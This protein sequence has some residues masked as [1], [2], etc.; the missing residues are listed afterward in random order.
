MR[1][2]ARS[3]SVSSYRSAV[4]LWCSSAKRRG[5]STS[6]RSR[7]SAIHVNEKSLAI[8]RS[9]AR[10]VA[11]SYTSATKR[12]PSD[13]LRK[14]RARTAAS[15]FGYPE[16]FDRQL[17]DR[18]NK[19]LKR[20]RAPA[21]GPV[22][23]SEGAGHTRTARIDPPAAHCRPRRLVGRAPAARGA[24]GGGLPRRVVPRPQPRRGRRPGPAQPD[25]AGADLAHPRG[26]LRGRRRHRHHEHVHGDDD[27]PG[28]LRASGPRSSRR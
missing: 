14:L 4:G 17:G 20:S 21:P 3:S 25:A 10:S 12:H 8:S 24:R 11:P 26:V 5:S 2:R 13:A 7:A 28:G 9:A 18:V 16:S 22:A 6:K 1:A 19:R 15:V 27:R 23:R